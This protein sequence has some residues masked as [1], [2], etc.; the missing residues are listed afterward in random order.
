MRMHCIRCLKMQA[1]VMKMQS[2]PCLSDEDL[3]HTHTH[4]HTHSLTSPIHT[5]TLKPCSSGLLI[6]TESWRCGS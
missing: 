2:D 6:H 1:R 3:S 4:T 5:K